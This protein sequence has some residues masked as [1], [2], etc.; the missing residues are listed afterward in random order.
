[1]DK[2]YFSPLKYSDSHSRLCGY[3]M[4]ARDSDKSQSVHTVSENSVSLYGQT[5]SAF[6]A[7]TRNTA[8][9]CISSP[10]RIGAMQ[11]DAR[12]SMTHLRVGCSE[13]D[14]KDEF[15][16]CRDDESASGCRRTFFVVSHGVGGNYW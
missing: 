15:V 8:S 6:W 10:G 9:R 1:M 5:G 11:T 14:W 12:D 16:V 2:N 3:D 4:A 7:T 13:Q